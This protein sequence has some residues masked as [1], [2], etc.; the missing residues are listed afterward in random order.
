MNCAYSARDQGV[1]QDVSLEV[2]GR[3]LL[4]K[5]KPPCSRLSERFS[6]EERGWATKMLGAMGVR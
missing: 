2:L 1:P 6:I 5:H 4:R 3:P